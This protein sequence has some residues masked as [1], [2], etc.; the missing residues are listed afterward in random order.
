[1]L[2]SI[3]GRQLIANFINVQVNLKRTFMIVCVDLAITQNQFVRGK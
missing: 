2:L 1:M 3:F